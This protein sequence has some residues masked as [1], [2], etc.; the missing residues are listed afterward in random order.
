[1]PKPKSNSLLNL[2]DAPSKEAKMCNRVRQIRIDNQLTQEEFCVMLQISVSL[3]KQIE[4]GRN[5]PSYDLL[6]KL[7]K[8]FKVTFEYL[9]IGK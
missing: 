3:L 7:H 8:R 9:I 5:A 4:Q 1:M 6:R 2:K